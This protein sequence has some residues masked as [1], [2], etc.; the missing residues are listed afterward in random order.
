M[1]YLYTAP[2]QETV[3]NKVTVP[4]VNGNIASGSL[5]RI[6][7]SQNNP[8]NYCSHKQNKISMHAKSTRTDFSVTDINFTL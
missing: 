4:V 3:R 7:K 5:K 6:C 2:T 8:K 1:V